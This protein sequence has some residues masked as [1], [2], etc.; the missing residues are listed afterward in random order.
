MGNETAG[1]ES[2]LLK[3]AKKMKMAHYGHI[4]RKEERCLKKE[5]VQ[6]T[7]A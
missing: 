3:S 4:K 1:V 2:N 7:H 5:M 6:G